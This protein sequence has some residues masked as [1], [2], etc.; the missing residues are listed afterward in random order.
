M[1]ILHADLYVRWE[2]FGDYDMRQPANVLLLCAMAAISVCATVSAQDQASSDGTENAPLKRVEPIFPDENKYLIFVEGEDAVSTNFNKEPTQNY[3]CSGS[4]ALQLSRKTNLQAGSTF[5]ADYVFYIEEDGIYELWYGGTPPGPRGEAYPSYSSPFQYYIDDPSRTKS[6]YREDMTVVENYA[7][8]YYWNLVREETLTQGRH[9]LRIF[10]KEKRSFDARFYFYLDCMFLVKKEGD[11]RLLGSRLPAVFPKNCD[12]RSMNEPFAWLDDYLIRVRDNPEDISALKD[13]SLIYSLLND[14]LNAIKNLKR[15]Q[16]LAPEDAGIKLLLAKNYIWMSEISVGLDLY[17]ELLRK[18]PSNVGICLEAGKVAGWTGRFTDSIDFFKAG[19][20][21]HPDN[22]DL[23]VNMGLSYLW[24]GDAEN[25]DKAIREAKD[26][27]GKDPDRIKALAR[28]FIVNGYPDKAVDIY[29]QGIDVAPADLQLYL[30]LEDTHLNAGK[31]KLAEEVKNTISRRFISSTKLTR[32]LDFYH[33]KIG[34]KDKVLD[35]YRNQLVTQPDNLELREMLAQTYFWN[36]LKEEAI[37]EYLNILGNHSFRKM[38]AMDQESMKL[39]ELMDRLTIL[40]AYFGK[41]EGTAADK[42]NEISTQAARYKANGTD[43]DKAKKE[44]ALLASLVADGEEIARLYEE[45]DR[46]YEGDMKTAADAI[47]KAGK[48]EEI[49]A[50]MTG[51]L[52]WEWDRNQSMSELDEVSRNGLVLAD[53]VLARTAQMEGDLQGAK[54]RYEKILASQQFPEAEFAYWQTLLWSGNREAADKA[55]SSYGKDIGAYAPYMGKLRQLMDSLSRQVSGSA[56]DPSGD[57]AGK[58]KSITDRLASLASDA[59][60]NNGAI[61]DTVK[62][63]KERLS[64]R[65]VRAYYSSQESSY[66]LRGE[67][68][69]F[70]LRNDEQDKAIVQYR[71][72]LAIDP[73]NVSAIYRLGTVYQWKKDWSEAM[74]AYEKVYKSDPGYENTASLYNGLARQFA[75]EVT[76]NANSLTEPSRLLIKA[77]AD[78]WKYINSF[79]KIGA[80]YDL[81]YIQFTRTWDTPQY[82]AYTVHGI[83]LGMLFDIFSI[84]LKINPTAGVNVTLKDYFYKNWEVPQTFPPQYNAFMFMDAM[85]Y[86]PFASLDFSLGLGDVLSVFGTIGYRQYFDTFAAH[87]PDADEIW[88]NSSL[89][90]NLNFLKAYP[91]REGSIRMYA[92]IDWLD[93]YNKIFNPGID[94]NMPLIGIDNPNIVFSLAGSGSYQNTIGDWN[95]GK[96]Y[97]PKEVYQVNGQ[98]VLLVRFGPREKQDLPAISLKFGGGIIHEMDWKFNPVLEK[99]MTGEAIFRIN[100]DKGS[101]GIGGDFSMTVGANEYPAYV[102]KPDAL[103]FWSMNVKVEYTA[104]IQSLLAP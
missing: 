34:L 2:E 104:R 9:Q 55:L 85:D 35:G 19:L 44:A 101:F 97:K 90:V 56:G 29:K 11:T 24:S 66:L 81:D 76:I 15:A 68:G 21:A 5:Y 18:D 32:Y 48:D 77:N 93:D 6:V 36:G 10:V 67:L 31:K 1:A 94:V 64:K 65:L 75:D 73:N 7:P 71:Q 98:A 88:L 50:K 4:R 12:D 72:V 57:L 96:Y 100:G 3:S 14:Y 51:T 89:F 95:V 27:A 43:P 30:L 62:S 40:S 69:D 79:L 78:Y 28:V 54:S 52:Q 42:R 38:K 8:S 53:H 45:A 80:G 13:V 37:A 61:A 60:P 86:S 26:K 82:Y 46:A 20:A 83:S 39:L 63:L 74:S 58:A 22:L 99:K 41:I 92:N 49:F 17:R 87:V 25:A 47:E 102:Y 84:N 16:T 91:Y 103:G 23:L 70:Y 33:E 59:R